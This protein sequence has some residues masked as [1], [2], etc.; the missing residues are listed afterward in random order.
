MSKRNSCYVTSSFQLSPSIHVALQQHEEGWKQEGSAHCRW[1]QR[2]HSLVFSEAPFQLR[3]VSHVLVHLVVECL[4]K[5]KWE[6][7]NSIFFNIICSGPTLLCKW[8]KTLTCNR[9]EKREWGET[10]I[11]VDFQMTLKLCFVSV[12]KCMLYVSFGWIQILRQEHSIHA[13]RILGTNFKWIFGNDFPKPVCWLLALRV[14]LH[15]N[16][17]F[18]FPVLHLAACFLV[19]CDVSVIKLYIFTLVSCLKVV[20]SM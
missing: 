8:W 7:L 4:K 5:T 20:H 13:F 16:L 12:W 15:S 6:A 11:Q 9:S 2:G 1:W 3:W 17:F 18:L 14:S 10:G 19:F